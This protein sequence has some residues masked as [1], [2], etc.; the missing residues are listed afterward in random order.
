MIPTVT[1]TLFIVT[2]VYLSDQYA[3][4][5]LDIM[6]S[7]LDMDRQYSCI[8]DTETQNKIERNLFDFGN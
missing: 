2:S 4:A 5:N 7:Y 3:N 8:V 6:P 1:S